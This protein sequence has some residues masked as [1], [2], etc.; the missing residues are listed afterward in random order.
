MT[1]LVTTC[2]LVSVVRELTVGPGTELVT[3]GPVIVS[4]TR[5]TN[6]SA[7]SVVWV[8]DVVDTVEVVVPPV[9]VVVVSTVVVLVAVAVGAV[10]VT[11][12]NA[13]RV[14][15]V[16]TV[17]RDWRML[18][19]VVT[20]L[21]GPPVNTVVVE[22]ARV[23]VPATVLVSV[24]VDTDVVLPTLT[25]TTTVGEKTVGVARAWIAASVRFQPLQPPNPLGV[26]PKVVV[27]TTVLLTMI[28]TTTVLVTGLPVVIVVGPASVDVATVLVLVTGSGVMVPVIV[29]VNVANTVKPGR[30][31][32][33]V[34]PPVVCVTIWVV[35]CEATV[36]VTVCVVV[37]VVV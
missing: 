31:E 11:V 6:V 10:M 37:T 26:H 17:T 9:V 29:M 13:V 23:V 33:I 15:V 14:L 35:V 28:K 32:V 27:V 20:V 24:C 8:E 21:V 34:L 12:V 30:V 22:G 18:D 7:T 1:V 25:V 16:V 19:V 4:V 3:A 5:F 2:V 36:L